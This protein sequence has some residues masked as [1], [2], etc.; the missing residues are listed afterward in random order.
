AGKTKIDAPYY[1]DDTGKGFVV[2]YD[3][4]GF[5]IE[6]EHTETEGDVSVPFYGK[7][8]YEVETNALYAVYRS[9]G[10]AYFKAKIG[11]LNEDVTIKNF[12]VIP[13]SIKD[14]DTGASAGVGGGFRIGPVSMEAEYT[15]I[16]EDVDF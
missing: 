4:G 5:G 13:G 3:F 7:G 1:D 9:L 16:E 8:D 10:T 11:V 12:G 15:V 14:D 2:G 6:F